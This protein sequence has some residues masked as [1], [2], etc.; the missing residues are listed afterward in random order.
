MMDAK[1]LTRRV[2][3]TPGT[4]N[5]SPIFGFTI[6]FESVSR[7]LLPD[8]S[9]INKVLAPRIFTDPGGSPRGE[10]SS[11]P[12]AAVVAKREAGEEVFVPLDLPTALAGHLEGG[13]LTWLG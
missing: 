13:Q 9:A 5:R 1:P 8:R 4:K 11:E 2:S 6:K 7:R 12:S 10:T 3:I